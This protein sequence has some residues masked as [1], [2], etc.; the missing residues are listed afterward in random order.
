MFHLPASKWTPLTL[1]RPSFG[2]A[3]MRLVPHTHEGRVITLVLPSLRSTRLVISFSLHSLLLLWVFQYWR[4]WNMQHFSDSFAAWDLTTGNTHNIWK[5]KTWRG[6]PPAARPAARQDS[7][8]G[9][10]VAV[11]RHGALLWSH[12]LC[13]CR[14]SRGDG[15][16]WASR[17]LDYCCSCVLLKPRVQRVAPDAC[18]S[19]SFIS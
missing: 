3:M 13:G 16:A 1:W 6:P 17:L 15:A 4:I 7:R 14:G 10:A 12:H 18:S 5:M 19:R 11:D 8:T 2:Q 9:Q